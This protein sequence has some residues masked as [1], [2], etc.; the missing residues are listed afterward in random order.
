MKT[1]H[2]EEKK[3][4]Q[5]RKLTLEALHTYSCEITYAEPIL[6]LLVSSFPPKHAWDY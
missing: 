6:F 2:K 3:K 1:V 4:D 5:T